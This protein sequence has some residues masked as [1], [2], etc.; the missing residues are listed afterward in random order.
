MAEGTPR[1]STPGASLHFVKRNDE[2][3]DDD[4]DKTDPNRDENLVGLVALLGKRGVGFKVDGPGAL[5]EVLRFDADDHR[6]F[7]RLL[8]RRADCGGR[9]RAGFQPHFHLTQAK[10]LT[11][12]QY[13]FDDLFAVD[14]GAIGRVEVFDQEV[15]GASS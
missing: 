9:G 15:G 2:A 7:K 11:W 5:F 14:E 4:K 1:L 12:F 3:G 13:R 8:A 10:D 6:L